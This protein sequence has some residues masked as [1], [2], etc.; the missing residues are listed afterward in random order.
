MTYKN[1]KTDNGIGDTLLGIQTAKL[2][3]KS[4]TFLLTIISFWIRLNYYY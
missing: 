3:S 1:S 2:K 4:P